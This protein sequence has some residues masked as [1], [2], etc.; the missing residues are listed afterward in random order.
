[1]ASRIVDQR[2]CRHVFFICFQIPAEPFAYESILVIANCAFPRPLS[3]RSFP[4]SH[5]SYIHQQ[6]SCWYSVTKQNACHSPAVAHRTALT[7]HTA[8]DPEGAPSSC[9]TASAQI[10]ID[11]IG[12]THCVHRGLCAYACQET[13]VRCQGLLLLWEMRICY[14]HVKTETDM[15][16]TV[17]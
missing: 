8:A 12:C 1:M 7:A 5:S 14:C 2:V 16:N 3:P 4:A 10:Q 11:T 15:A 17:T 13:E 9:A 6:C